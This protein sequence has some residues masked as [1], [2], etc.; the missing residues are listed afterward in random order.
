MTDAIDIHKLQTL[1]SKTT[2]GVWKVYGIN[3]KYI[4]A[5]HPVTGEIRQDICEAGEHN[6]NFIVEVRKQLPIILSTI[7]EQDKR[8]RELEVVNRSLRKQVQELERQRDYLAF[9]LSSGGSDQ[10]ECDHMCIPCEHRN[11]YW[12]EAGAE[13]RI[14][15]WIS[16]AE[17]AVKEAGK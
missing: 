9:E 7:T 15:C 1:L 12:C 3:G 17:Q 5:F 2:W 10:S 16:V 14:R 13:G 6:M 11:G 4:A 8:I